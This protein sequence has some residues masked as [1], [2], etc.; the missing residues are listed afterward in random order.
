MLRSSVVAAT[1][2]LKDKIGKGN[3]CN[4]L[5]GIWDVTLIFFCSQIYKPLVFV[6]KLVYNMTIKNCRGGLKL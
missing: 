1:R 4:V 3:E 2:W 6:V 5:F